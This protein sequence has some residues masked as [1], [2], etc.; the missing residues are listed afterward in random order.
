MHRR[1]HALKHQPDYIQDNVKPGPESWEARRAR[2]ARA[3]EQAHHLPGN[4]PAPDLEAFIHRYRLEES[5]F[6]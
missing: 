4:Q 6:A 2:I 3:C 5:S 1:N